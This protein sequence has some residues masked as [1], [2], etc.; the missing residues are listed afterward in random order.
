MYDPL[1]DTWEY[2]ST[3]P[4]RGFTYGQATAVVDDEIYVI[5]GKS[6][7]GLNEALDSKTLR[8][9][10]TRNKWI[11]GLS[12]IPFNSNGLA[13]D[14]IAGKVYVVGTGEHLQIY[15]PATDAWTRG[16]SLPV[17]TKGPSVV[18]L[19]EELYVFGGWSTNFKSSVQIYDPETNRWRLSTDLSAPR[20]YS[21]AAF[22]EGRAYIFGG[23]GPL[24]IDLN[25]NEIMNLSPP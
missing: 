2:E 8:Y 25:Y 12:P 16:A 4:A 22:H 20:D 10:P 19:E 3:I 14:T 15:D 13:A 11:G 24:A 17:P 1:L 23:H 7:A 9:E 18:V 6:G 5:G 21:A